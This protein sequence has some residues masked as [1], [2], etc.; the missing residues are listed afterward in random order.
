MKLLTKELENRFVKIGS[1]ETVE[2]PIVIAKFFNPMGRGYWFATEYDSAER[3]FFG[4]V[5][6]F[7]DYNDE[8]GSFSLDELESI[9]IFGVGIERDMYFAEVPL[10][11]IKAKYT[12]V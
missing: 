8:L 4:Y 9:K 12:K 11:E 10:S 7:G 2:D 6:L 3:M 1:Q 5:S